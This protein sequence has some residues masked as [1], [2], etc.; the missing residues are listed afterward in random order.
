MAPSSVDLAITSLEQLR[1]R[2]SQ[3]LRILTEAQ[4]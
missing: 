4:G 2:G 3:G 1:Q